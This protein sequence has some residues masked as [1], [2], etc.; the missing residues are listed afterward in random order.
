MMQQRHPPMRL[1]GPSQWQ[2]HLV[3]EGCQWN[4]PHLL[5]LQFNFVLWVRHLP[6]LTVPTLVRIMYSSSMGGWATSRRCHIWQPRFLMSLE[7]VRCRL[8][9]IPLMTMTLR[10]LPVLSVAMTRTRTR[11][12]TFMYLVIKKAQRQKKRSQEKRRRRMKADLKL[13]F[14]SLPATTAEQLMVLQ[15]VARGWRK[16]LPNSL[17]LISSSDRL[18]EMDLCSTT[19]LCPLSVIR[20]AGFTRDT[21]FPSFPRSCLYLRRMD[22]TQRRLSFILTY[23]AQRPRL[24]LALHRTPISLSPDLQSELLE[25]FL[26]LLGWI[27]SG[28]MLPTTQRLKQIAMS[29]RKMSRTTPATLMKTKPR[30]E[31]MSPCCSSRRPKRMKLKLKLTKS[32]R[33]I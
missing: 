18:R 22:S 26:I 25:E 6:F 3:P 21:H 11:T 4:H 1:A 30:L 8:V 14:T 12:I 19:L 31:M 9:P 33:E 16:R 15:Q 32:Q 20:S 17:L 7:V 13:L 27:S 29:I 23:F 24:I 28:L 10:V 2:F 5:T